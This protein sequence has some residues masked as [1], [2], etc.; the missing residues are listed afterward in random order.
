M[1]FPVSSLHS[2]HKLSSTKKPST[3]RNRRHRITRLLVFFFLI[4]TKPPGCGRQPFRAPL[5]A[6]KDAWPRPGVR[7]RLFFFFFS[8]G[9]KHP[10]C[11]KQPFRA[12]LGAEKGAW[13]RPGV[14]KG[15]LGARGVHKRTSERTLG[16]GEGHRSAPSSAGRAPPSH[17]E[18]RQGCLGAHPFFR[19]QHFEATK[20]KFDQF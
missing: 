7:K 16:C 19:R 15:H 18:V 4:G 9:T 20:L 17:L 8:I 3:K 12:P 5:G 11:G 6:E 13:A 10:G 2:P 14:Q 1:S